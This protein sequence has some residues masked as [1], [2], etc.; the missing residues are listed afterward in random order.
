MMTTICFIIHVIVLMVVVGFVDD[1]IST[2]AT[3]FSSPFFL[4]SD[5]SLFESVTLFVMHTMLT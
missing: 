3:V 4:L 5:T 2:A 1:H